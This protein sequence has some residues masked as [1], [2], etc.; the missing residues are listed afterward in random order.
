[1]AAPAQAA[2]PR[3]PASTWLAAAL[4][5]FGCMSAELTAVRLLA[6]HFGDSAYVW[7][8][9]IGVILAALAAGAWL[10]GRLAGSVHAARHAQSLL[11]AA[12]VWSAAA[13]W[14]A[15]PL[16]A[17]LMPA[18]LPLDSAMPA[19]VRGSFVATAVLFAPAMLWLGAIS[20]LLIAIAVRGG[21]DVGRAAGGLAAAGTIGSLAG[22]FAA[23]HV[24]V[25]LLG[26]RV[27]MAI[28]GC[29]LAGAAVLV[30]VAGA[31]TLGGGALL[32]AAV[33]T[34]LH[35]GCDGALRAPPAGS[36]LLAEVES[37]IQ[38]LQVLRERADGAVR[39]SLRINEGLDS[40]HSL[41]IE[42]SAFTGGSYYDWHALAPLLAGD[43]ARPAGLRALSIG[44]AAGTLRAVYARVHPGATVTA[45]DIDAATMQLGD[46]WFPG[47]KADGPRFALDGR[48]FLEHAK[49]QWHVIH[50]DAYAHQVYVPAHLASREF[51]AAAKRCLL[52]G[53][54]IA[55]NVGA[56]RADDPVLC[57]IR[58]TLAEVFGNAA[59]MQVPNSRNA[60]LVA[61]AGDPPDPRR[62]ASFVFGAERLSDADAAHWREI[63]AAAASSPWT[64]STAAGEVLVDDRPVLDR[65]L[66]GSYVDRRD[67]ATL[68]ACAGSAPPAA[69]ELDAYAAR[70]RP[71]WIA[72]LAA[73]AASSAPTASLREWAGDARWA[74]RE[75]RSA[76]AEFAA[77]IE[78]ASDQATR[79]RLEGKL[80]EIDAE[81]V[82]VAQA[83]GVALRNGWLQAA[84]VALFA[85]A[86]VGARR[87]G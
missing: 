52:P 48:V 51:F 6:P 25:P 32:I 64:G 65:L 66:A 63:V 21:V 14:F 7:T 33:A 29:A 60:L 24:L 43:G 69:A 17:W 53:G 68:V 31:R 46:R 84:A 22:T 50:V 26:C 9:V 20:P 2:G 15:G 70:R 80:R 56:L 73:V 82:P 18:D 13:P 78:L 40:F 85:L 67:E 41:A 74:L 83:E 75:L 39:T 4:A 38:F 77:G 12:A 45:V 55:C 37:P 71:D 34:A 47:P 28:A 42:G 86:L 35:H 62:L 8:N 49:E 36:E 5:G 23:T 79:A 81:L 27:A 57:A 87:L 11:A 3:V 72:V 61:R 44:D 1:V 19:M 16:G 30:R 76:R 59:S 54:V 10:G 58:S